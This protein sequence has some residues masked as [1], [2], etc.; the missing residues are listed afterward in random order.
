MRAAEFIKEETIK[1][2]G[3]DSR[4]KECINRVNEDEQPVIKLSTS[5][6][7]AAKAWIEK[8]YAKYPTMW[9]NNHVMLWG[10]GEDQQMAVFELVPSL[11]KRGAVEVKWIQ[12]YPLRQGVGTKAM[13]ELQQ[14]AREDGISLTLFPWDKGQVSQAK[15]TKFYKGHGFKPVAKGS[16]SLHWSPELD[17]AELDPQG[18]GSTPQGTDVDYFGIQVKMRPSMFMRL[19][20]PLTANAENPEVAQHMEKGGK[21]A[22]PFLDIQEP[23][24]WEDGDFAN[25]AKVR[26]H[27]GRNRMKKWIQMKGDEPIPV[28]IFFRNANRRKYITPEMIKQL[29]MGVFSESGNWVSGPLFDP[30]TAQ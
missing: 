22:Y 17:E 21:I 5:G 8:V 23:K 12:A 19:A 30:G 29:S 13:R 6:N 20:A 25:E 11:S 27:E 4:V 10:E 28:N 24:E 26:S 3:P 2:S 14:L 1:I 9:Q 7:A 18:W 16:K 15:L